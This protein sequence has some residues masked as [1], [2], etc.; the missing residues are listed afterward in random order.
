MFKS[1]INIATV[2]AI[3]LYIVYEAAIFVREL[4]L[5]RNSRD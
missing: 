3:I 5:E 4:I 2:A 1:L